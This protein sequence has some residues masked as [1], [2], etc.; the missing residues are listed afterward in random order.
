MKDIINSNTIAN[1]ISLLRRHPK[2]RDF[3]FI[4]VEG[5]SDEVFFKNILNLNVCKPIP[6]SG[7]VNTIL[8]MEKLVQ[9]EEKNI[10]AVVD[11]DFDVLLQNVTY[12]HMPVFY[13]DY[14]DLETLLLKSP[15]LDK[16]LNRFADVEKMNNFSREKLIHDILVKPAALIGHIKFLSRL[17]NW[18]LKFK[19]LR[20]DKF[21][22]N[23]LEINENVLIKEI[24]ENTENCRLNIN[25]I[26]SALQSDHRQYDPWVLATGH[27]VMKI[28]HYALHN[29][30]GIPSKIEVF[31]YPSNIE[32]VLLITYEAR[33]FKQT[34][35]YYHIHKWQEKKNKKELF[36]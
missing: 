16:F 26:K 2:Y 5:S 24:I 8:T 15:A 20:I 35:L 23:K 30:F 14:H 6:T 10:I 18:N 31:H 33:Y 22:N 32:D 36:N 3:T 7:K 13:T 25:D 21:L 11:Q 17:N 34:K 19:H 12:R 27:D 29:I 1:Q 9:R 4:L 28:L